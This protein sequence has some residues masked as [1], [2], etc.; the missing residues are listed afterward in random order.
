MKQLENFFALVAAVGYSDESKNSLKEVA[1]MCFFLFFL[2][3]NIGR[4]LPEE[5]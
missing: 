2:L 5:E 1:D 3:A 4:Q